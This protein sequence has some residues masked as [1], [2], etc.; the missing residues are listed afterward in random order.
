MFAHLESE[1]VRYYTAYCS[2]LLLLADLDGLLGGMAD[3]GR[4]RRSLCR[5]F[6]RATGLSLIAPA[7]ML[8]SG[9]REKDAPPSLG[10]RLLLH[11]A[12]MVLLLGLVICL[13]LM[14]TDTIIWFVGVWR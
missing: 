2:L 13:D 5:R 8:V 7:G 9:S 10:V 11:F 4:A 12:G 1:K 3:S 6:R 14:F